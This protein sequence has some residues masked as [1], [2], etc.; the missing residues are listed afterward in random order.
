[1]TRV[2]SRLTLLS[3]LATAGCGST[4]P[5]DVD[6]T[7]TWA[8]TVGAIGIASMS[9]NVTEQSNQVTA[10]GQWTPSG[11]GAPA[12]VT[13]QGLHFGLD[14]NL[15]LKFTTATGPFEYST[16]GRVET[17]NSFH[18]VFPTEANPIR[19]VFTR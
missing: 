9:L 3:L 4:D 12:T 17:E 16:E 7:G 15:V 1:M 18:L 13:A 5:T 14:I 11:G 19:V 6:L 10:T 2:L 8:A